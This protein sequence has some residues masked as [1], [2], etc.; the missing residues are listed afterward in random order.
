MRESGIQAI[1]EYVMD[2]FVFTVVE[3]F[4]LRGVIPLSRLLEKVH[5]ALSRISRVITHFVNL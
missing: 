5:T 4:K 1:F 2:Q 3:P